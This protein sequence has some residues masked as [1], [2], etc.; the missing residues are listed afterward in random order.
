[1][2]GCVL[3]KD[4]VSNSDNALLGNIFCQDVHKRNG[5]SN[6]I[7]EDSCIQEMPSRASFLLTK[8]NV[9]NSANALPGDIFCQ[10]VHKLNGVG[11][12]I[13]EDSCTQEMPSRASF[14]L[15]QDI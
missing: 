9:S 15:T 12:K 5:V 3:T 10:D 14:I 1:M 13:R 2:G 8:D 6:K 11:N 7:R 4:N